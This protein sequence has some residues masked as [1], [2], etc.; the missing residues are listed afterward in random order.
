MRPAAPPIASLAP[1][2][3][4]AECCALACVAVAITDS[5]SSP[6][7]PQR[8]Q[9]AAAAPAAAAARAKAAACFVAVALLTC[10]YSLLLQASKDPESG[11]FR[12]SPLSVTFIAETAKLLFSLAAV[13]GTSAAAAAAPQL[14]AADCARAA[15]PAILY[16]VQNNLVFG[17]M[18]HLDAPLYQLL[19]NLKIVATALLTR[20]IL[21]RALTRLQVRR[22][23][24]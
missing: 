24:F 1:A 14:R 8:K 18:A 22:C 7:S 19:S 6:S 20:I 5:A 11:R 2:P 10:S 12:Y 13:Y 21:R 4:P 23:G 3:A 15:V 9:H 16:C 17:A